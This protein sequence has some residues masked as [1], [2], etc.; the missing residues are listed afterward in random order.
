[1]RIKE[2]QYYIEKPVAYGPIT[3]IWIRPKSSDFLQRMDTATTNVYIFQ[4][5][6]DSRTVY[7][8]YVW[9]PVHISEK[10]EQEKQRLAELL[11]M[12]VALHI[13]MPLCG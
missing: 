13:G 8:A 7:D 1:M 9:L 12:R 3:H 6:V 2:E 4:V 10:A 5:L 11:E